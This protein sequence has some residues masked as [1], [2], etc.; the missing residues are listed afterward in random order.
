MGILIH[1]VVQNKVE[2]EEF[3]VTESSF[4]TELSRQ[5]SAVN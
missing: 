4:S 2:S 3:K 5:L 1:Y